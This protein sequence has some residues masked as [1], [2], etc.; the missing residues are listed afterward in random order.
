MITAEIEITSDKFES[1]II[2]CRVLKKEIP[3]VTEQICSELLSFANTQ[4]EEGEEV[5]QI[6]AKRPH[7][8]DTLPQPFWDYFNGMYM[9]KWWN[10]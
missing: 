5:Y 2:H 7:E 6:S 9:I 10:N 4:L 1:G 3:E 8:N